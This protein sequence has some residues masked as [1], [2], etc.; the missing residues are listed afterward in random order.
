LLIFLLF[1]VAEYAIRILNP[2][3]RTTCT[4]KNILIDSLY[5]S[6]TG[7]IKN[8]TDNCKNV[9]KS[10]NTISCWTYKS[11]YKIGKKILYLG[12]SVTMGIG[13]ENDSTFAGRINN[14]LKNVSIINP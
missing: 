10:V 6:S 13:V 4:S 9:I 11:S 14:D 2:H 7:L 8:S 1:L 5:Y 12:D 3:I